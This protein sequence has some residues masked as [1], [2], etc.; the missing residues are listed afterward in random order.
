M[1]MIEKRLQELY[2]KKEAI[3]NEITSLESQLKLS[4]PKPC[5]PSK[6]FSKQEKINLLENSISG[7]VFLMMFILLH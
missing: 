5:K 7:I 4:L 2:L 6:T 1:Q 3:Q